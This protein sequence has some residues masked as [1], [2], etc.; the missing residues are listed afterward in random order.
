MVAVLACSGG[1]GKG[2]GLNKF[3]DHIVESD[4][5]RGADLLKRARGNRF[6][7]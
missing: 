3:K 1:S 2:Q 7:K 5:M 4:K 6:P